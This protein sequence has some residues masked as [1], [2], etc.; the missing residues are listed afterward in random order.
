MPQNFGVR[1]FANNPSQR[2]TARFMDDGGVVLASGNSGDSWRC[3]LQAGQGT[4]TKAGNARVEIRHHPSLKEWFENR[5]AGLEHGFV[6]ESIKAD[7]DAETIGLQ[8]KFALRGDLSAEADPA[9]TVGDLRFV[10][11]SGDPVLGYRKLVVTGPDG[12]EL[13]ATMAAAQG[14]R[15]VVI[16][17]AIDEDQ[18]FPIV[19]DPLIAKFEAGLSPTVSGDGGAFANFGGSVSIDGDLVAIGALG[20]AKVYIF[21]RTDGAWS[22]EQRLS[23]AAEN[24]VIGG[25]VSVDGDRLIVGGSGDNGAGLNHGAA[26]VYRREGAAW[27]QEARL[28]ASDGSFQDGFGFSV[29]L[30]GDRALV[31]APGYVDE[32]DRRVGRAYIFKRIGTDWVEEDILE[33]S[34]FSAFDP[35][36]GESVSLSGDTACVGGAALGTDLKVLVYSRSG[37]RWLR[38]HEI[39]PPGD[40]IRFGSSLSLDGDTVAISGDTVVIGAPDDTNEVDRAA[41]SAYLFERSGDS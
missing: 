11:T 37:N 31:G 2:F 41:G 7:A 13:E 22:L 14:G 8:I 40:Q 24:S 34:S 35:G 1:L 32:Q 18:R 6:V 4:P 10:N 27:V 19:I 20:D 39:D 30:D 38:S 29:S 5:G 33:A 15:E 21:A 17:V 16:S 12:D 9:S 26:Y 25:S 28:L 36:Y 3:R 23:Q